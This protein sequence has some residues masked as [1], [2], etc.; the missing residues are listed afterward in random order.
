MVEEEGGN[1]HF[2]DNGLV[3]LLE[4]IREHVRVHE[5]LATHAQNVDGFLEELHLDPRHVVLLHVFHALPD[6]GV[7]LKPYH[8]H[9]IKV[10]L[11][12]AVLELSCKQWGGTL[13]NTLF[14]NLRLCM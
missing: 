5:R 4:I 6:A 7:Q 9:S 3:V 10:L 11:F 8:A 13:C 12:F 2:E 1:P 14:S